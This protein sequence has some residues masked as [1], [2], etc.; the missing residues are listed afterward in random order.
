MLCHYEQQYHVLQ[1][2]ILIGPRFCGALQLL[3][4]G[5]KRAWFWL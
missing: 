4:A 1:P 5:P 3:A 2:T